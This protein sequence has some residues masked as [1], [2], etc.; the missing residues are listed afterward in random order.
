MVPILA[1]TEIIILR[2]EGRK[3]TW[4]W[5]VMCLDDVG[6]FGESSEGKCNHISF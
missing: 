1:L 4:I 2:K 3:Q 5:E 6:E